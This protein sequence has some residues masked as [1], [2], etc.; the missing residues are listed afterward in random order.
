[1]NVQG[2][3]PLELTSWSPCSPR[4]S[5]E[6]SPRPQSENINSLALS[7]LYGTVLTS[8]HDHWKTITLTTCTFVGK[9]MSLPF[10][11]L[12]KLV[13]LFLPRSKCLSISW[14]QSPSAVILEPKKIKSFIVSIVSPST[15]HEVMGLDAMIFVFWMLSVKPTFSLS[16]FA[17]IKR[18]FRSHGGATFIYFFFL[19]NCHHVPHSA[20]SF[21]LSCQEY[22]RL[23]IS[24]P[25]CQRFLFLDSSSSNGCEVVCHCD[26]N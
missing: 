8:K 18:L 25:P 6:S 5:W 15:C 16:S 22:I 4:D 14:L 12:S 2:R 17:F 19:W 7:L 13:I 10:N 21:T 23:P 11:M 20:H 9:V 26:F 24:P 1:M 3:F